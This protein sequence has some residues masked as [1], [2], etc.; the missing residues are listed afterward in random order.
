[1][2][3]SAPDSPMTA[4]SARVR[5]AF[6]SSGAARGRKE[7]DTLWKFMS[8]EARCAALRRMFTLGP[9]AAAARD[10]L[11]RS[12]KLLSLPEGTVIYRQGENCTD[13]IYFVCSGGTLPPLGATGPR[14]HVAASR[15]KSSPSADQNERNTFVI[16]HY[17]GVD[18]RHRSGDG[19]AATNGV[20]VAV[21]EDVAGSGT[22]P[23]EA[24]G[25]DGVQLATPHKRLDL[26]PR[27]GV[28][29]AGESI[30]ETLKLGAGSPEVV[31][32]DRRLASVVTLAKKEMPDATDVDA[33]RSGITVLLQVS[34]AACRAAAPKVFTKAEEA[35]SERVG[36]LR[37]LH[38]FADWPASVSARV[39]QLA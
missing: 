3:Q 33:K 30:G 13:F 10:E 8:T 23:W 38:I 28:L 31:S 34:A 1:M 29:L 2:A 17:S 15:A 19:V 16:V 36:M 37:Q 4:L 6:A 25:A 39:A 32:G 26:G 21:P 11:C 14:V 18:V 35:L 5:A 24:S 20:P 9:V 7:L 27:V 12:A 22:L